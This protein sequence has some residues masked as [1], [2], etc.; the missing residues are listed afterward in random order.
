MVKATIFEPAGVAVAELKS[1]CATVA[2]RA[3]SEGFECVR[4]VR[5]HHSGTFTDLW[6]DGF[7]YRSVLEGGNLQNFILDL[8]LV[9]GDR[10]AVQEEIVRRLERTGAVSLVAI[11][12]PK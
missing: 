4:Y 1:H 10:D 7:S 6:K 9:K 2:R 12:T 11:D 8:G 3:F 5:G